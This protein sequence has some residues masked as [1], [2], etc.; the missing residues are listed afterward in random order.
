MNQL[1]DSEEVFGG[2]Y[3]GLQLT[4]KYFMEQDHQL[5]WIMLQRTGF[6]TKK[7]LFHALW[8]RL[9]T[10]ESLPHQESKGV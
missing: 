2:K 4:V 10:L 5:Q 1:A 3:S 8:I 9:H 7:S 6:H